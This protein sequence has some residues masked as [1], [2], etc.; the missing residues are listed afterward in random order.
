MTPLLDVN[1]LIT[2]HR[3]LLPHHSEVRAYV[4]G[5]RT[6]SSASGVPELA[7]SGFVRVVTAPKPFVPPS[8][9]QEAFDFAAAVLASPNCIP[10]RPSGT[11]WAV[12]ETLARRL[13]ARWKL[14]PDVY[15]AA[16]AI[17]QGYEIVTLDSDYVKIP[18]LTWRH[19]LVAHATT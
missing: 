3:D 7:L 11:H 1:I 8:T 18:G 12:F 13:N 16:M 17:D 10:V 2:A 6:G 4:D 9:T 14:I 15:F 19:P 5:L